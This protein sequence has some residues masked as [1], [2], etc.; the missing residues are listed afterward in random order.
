VD[1]KAGTAAKNAAAS[2]TLN[3][4]LKNRDMA[5]STGA[6][7]H[8]LGGGQG[9]RIVRNGNAPSDEGSLSPKRQD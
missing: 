1:Q 9:L 4:E 2:I 6:N 7:K 3:N 8:Q 5:T